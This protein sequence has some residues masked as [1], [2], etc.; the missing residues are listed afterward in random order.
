MSLQPIEIKKIWI[1]RFKAAFV[2]DNNNKKLFI[3]TF[4]RHV[5]MDMIDGNDECRSIEL[6]LWESSGFSSGFLKYCHNSHTTHAHTRAHKKR[7]YD[8]HVEWN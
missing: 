4:M 3:Y 8:K 2:A 5:K 6:N 7:N 1:I